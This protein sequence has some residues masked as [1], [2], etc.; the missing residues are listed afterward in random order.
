MFFSLLLK[1]INDCPD[2]VAIKDLNR[3]LTYKEL[4]EEV[5]NKINSAKKFGIKESAIVLLMKNNSCDWITDF[6]A[7]ILLKVKVIMISNE[8]TKEQIE[9][10]NKKTNFLLV[11]NEENSKLIF[12]HYMPTENISISVPSDNSELVYHV[13]SGS[14]DN[15]KICIRSLK[16]LGYEGMMY[17]E[18]LMISRD[19]I[20]VC[21]LPIYHS[22]AFGAVIISGLM[23]GCEIVLFD[24]YSPR[25]YLKQL[26]SNKATL[27]FAV[28]AMLR[29]LTSMK[30]NEEI[31]LSHLRY[32]VVGAGIIT[33]ELFLNFK[34]KFNISLSSNYGS[35]ETGGLITR[36]EEKDFPS[37]GK[38]MKN[39]DIQIRDNDGNIIKNGFEGELWVK[40]PSLM[41]RYFDSVITLDKDG[42]YFTGDLAKKDNKDNIY[43]TGRIKNIVNIGG[44]KVNP[45][46][47]EELIKTYPDV[48][49]VMIVKKKKTNGEEY[50]MAY[51]SIKKEIDLYLIKKFLQDKVESY[52][53]PA[54]I[55]IVSTIP[56]NDLGKIKKEDL[57]S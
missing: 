11:I 3:Q 34:N 39:V 33:E 21:P 42:F 10:I 46:F 56:R 28:P 14:T 37:V 31:D 41:S 40:A 47:I 23:S 54:I 52:M 20:I 2:R 13:S 55:K 26:M 12:D 8:T 43:I 19:D 16:Q 9:Y 1:N 45:V 57:K 18:K 6:L 27:S 53:I 15:P 50:M 32:L 38:A 35:T 4:W 44:K 5:K 7:L 29:L 30:I 24:K 51:I 22:F 36:T 48:E 17:K 25:K 49:D